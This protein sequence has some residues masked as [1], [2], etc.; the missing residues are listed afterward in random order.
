MVILHGSW[1]QD[2]LSPECVSE[3]GT[4]LAV[5]FLQ[6]HEGYRFN[7]L[8]METVGAAE[9]GRVGVMHA[10]R[11]LGHF[12]VEGTA[13]ALWVI[14]REDALSVMGSLV[15]PLFH[16][17]DPLLWLRDADQQ[18]LL[19][20]LEGLTDEE[21]CAKLSLSLTAIKKRWI[22]IFERTIH[23]HPD[24]FPGVDHQDNGQK[25]SR[26]KRHHVLA[27]MRA[28]PEEL[29]PIEFRAP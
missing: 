24:L 1:C 2:V 13:R 7:R 8:I 23:T 3:I 4:A 25:R 29:R 21:L 6:Q 22:S 10:W 9:A 27:Y 16:H 12:E 5:R 26:Q 19:A 17:R 14:T 15:N 20:A 11:A 18:L 28:H